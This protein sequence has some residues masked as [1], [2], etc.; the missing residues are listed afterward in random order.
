[1]PS[2]GAHPGA[3]STQG[4]AVSTPAR[5]SFAFQPGALVRIMLT[6]LSYLTVALAA[7]AFSFDFGLRAGGPWLA[8]VAALNGAVFA[9]VLLDALRDGW[10]R[11]SARARR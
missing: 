7:A 6:G 2:L 1:M 10:R 11:R 9:T 8:V 4:G 3:R 5:A